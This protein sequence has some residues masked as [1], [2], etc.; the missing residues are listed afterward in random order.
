MTELDTMSMTPEQLK[1]MRTKMGLSQHRLAEMLG[2]SDRSRISQ[3]E[4]GLTR[5]PP[6]VAM[7]IKMIGEK[8]DV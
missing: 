7:L 1:E 8:A 3:F 2:Y 5:I 6:R 4:T